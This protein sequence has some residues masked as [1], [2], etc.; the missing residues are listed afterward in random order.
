MGFHGM[1]LLRGLPAAAAATA[2]IVLLVAPSAQAQRRSCV[3]STAQTAVATQT[4]P[5]RFGIYP[6]GPVG[7]VN[8]K[9][10]PR[11]ED[12]AKRLAALQGLRGDSPFV[13]RLYAGWTGDARAD[14]VSGW[15]DDEIRQYTAA[16]F[17]V[18]L[19]VR[20]KPADPDPTASPAAFAAY[21]RGIVRR[22]GDDPGF[23]SLQVTNEA[24]LPGAPEA[25]DGAFAG[26]VRALV[27]GVVA[28]K[29]EASR[30]GHDQVRVGFNWGYDERPAASSRFWAEVGRVGGRTFARSVD[31]VGL[32]SYPGT[33]S[34]QL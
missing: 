12:P 20:Y 16:G 31:W 28:A 21:L 24:N 18:E 26:A 1:R 19:A 32:N 17:Q 15:L 13:V 9:A 33:W 7:S 10:P 27:K 3:I 23:T 8:P 6:G 30:G 34:P 29:D 4:A 11:P 2:L 22:Y 14:D 25:S 5:L